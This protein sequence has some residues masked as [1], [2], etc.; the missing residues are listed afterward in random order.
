M[1]YLMGV[2]EMSCKNKDW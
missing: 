1:I 2:K